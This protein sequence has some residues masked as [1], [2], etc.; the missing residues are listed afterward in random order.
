MEQKLLRIRGVTK[1]HPHIAAR[2]ME[3]T[4]YSLEELTRDT[5]V[6]AVD[7]Q[8]RMV[9]YGVDA[10]WLSHHPPLVPEPFTP[11]AGEMWSK[12]DIDYWIA[13]I[14]QVVEEAYTDPDLVKTA[15]H[16]QVVHQL[17]PTG[18]DDPDRWA[19]TWRAYRRKQAATA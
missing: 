14:E 1:S 7:V 18:L 4:R 19:T 16:N 17:D 6:T 2:R 10:F 12:E 8:N 5:G 15:P 13:V 9:D 3:M 11:E